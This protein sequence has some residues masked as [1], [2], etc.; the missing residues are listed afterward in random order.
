[1]WFADRN[2]ALR[3]QQGFVPVRKMVR[4]R[5]CRPEVGNRRHLLIGAVL[6]TIQIIGGESEEFARI[7]VNGSSSDE[8]LGY[9]ASMRAGTARGCELDRLLL[10]DM[11]G[12]GHSGETPTAHRS[13]LSPHHHPA[14]GQR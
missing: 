7:A 13:L 11:A 5:K 6:M 10:I 14:E 8:V 1:M 3:T 12:R 4:S 2:G 9:A